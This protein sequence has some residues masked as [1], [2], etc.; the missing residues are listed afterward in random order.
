MA[1][2]VLVLSGLARAEEPPPAPA[3]AAEACRQADAQGV[4]PPA[5]A[6]CTEY[7]SQLEQQAK[8]LE[9]QVKVMEAQAKRLELQGKI[10]SANEPAAPKPDAPKPPAAPPGRPEDED[11]VLEVFGGQASIRYQGGDYIVRE[12]QSL[13]RGGRVEQVSLDGVVIV[14]G[15]VRRAL[16]FFIGERR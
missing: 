12:G 9:S 6:D 5:S 8:R 2:L 11:R 10:R 7:Q 4:P 15:R 16:P 3:A 14:D 1:L 13:P